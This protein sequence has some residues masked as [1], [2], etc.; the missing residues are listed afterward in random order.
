MGEADRIV[1]TPLEKSL[2]QMLMIRLGE[3]RATA[4]TARLL[5]I[6][7]PGGILFSR[8]HLRTPQSA[9]ELLRKIASAL[10]VPPL[11]ALEEEGGTVDPLGVIFP[12][13]PAP[14]AVAQKGAAA[15]ERLGELA[16]AGLKLL[17]FNANLAPVLDLSTPF[18]DP[19][20]GARAFSAD[21]HE[22]ARCGKAFVRGLGRRKVLACAKHFPGLGSLR[23]VARSGLPLSGKTMAGMW[24][25]D[26]VPYRELLH[27][28]PL[29]MVGRGAYKAYDFELPRPAL[30]SENVGEG[31]LRV[32][33]AYRGVAVAEDLDEEA[34]RSS[35]ELGEA[36]VRSVNAGC[37]L[38]LVGG[39]KSL[40]QAFAGLKRGVESG[41]ISS[42]R[43]EQALERIRFAKKG[44]ARPSGRVTASA[45]L[46]LTRQFEDFS[47]GCRP[48][49]QKIA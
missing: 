38:L 18:S 33:L 23:M 40:E 37:D 43:L 25:E 32:K 3:E 24:R 31:L 13:L 39:E 16:G 36:A 5:R 30:F 15:V 11:L 47:R 12:P 17:G 27:Q 35:V 10:P 1:S 6:V 4:A 45:C 21:A 26:L 29:V 7:N 14:R 19:G 42:E 46:E 8:R 22:V 48:L 49:E 9:H 20:L 44:L 28:L 2:G 41:K 34:R